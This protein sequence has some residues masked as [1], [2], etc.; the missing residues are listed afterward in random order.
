MR[1]DGSIIFFYIDGEKT[2]ESDEPV[3]FNANPVNI[4]HSA[5]YTVDGIIDEVKLWAK[6]LTPDEINVAMKGAA[7]VKAS[8]EKHSLLEEPDKTYVPKLPAWKAAD[9]ESVPELEKTHSF[10][11]PVPVSSEKSNPSASKVAKVSLDLASCSAAH[12]RNTSENRNSCGSLDTFKFSAS[13]PI[14]P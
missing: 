7:A 5:P 1:W 11:L 8:K 6:A 2:G 12:V 4:A 14:S 13:L 3:V 10:A 9:E